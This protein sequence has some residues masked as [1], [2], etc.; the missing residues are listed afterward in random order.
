MSLLST[1]YSSKDLARLL[2][3]LSNNKSISQSTIASERAI[4]IFKDL[5]KHALKFPS[6]NIYYLN[7]YLDQLKL[8]I[9]L[10][11]SHKTLG[12]VNKGDIKLMQWVIANI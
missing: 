10:N 9:N 8:A 11:L 1:K 7:L 4:I 5:R 3:L 6:N 12:V 2:R